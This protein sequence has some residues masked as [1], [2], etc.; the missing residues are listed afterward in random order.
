MKTI[1]FILPYF[2]CGKGNLPEMAQVFFESCKFNQTIEWLFY[3]DCN[4]ER[5]S[6]PDNIIVKEIS[7][8]EIQRRAQNKYDFK[9]CLNY[10]YK[11]C[12]FKPAYGEIFEEELEGIDFWGFCDLDII[13]GDIRKFLTDEILENNDRI[14]THGHCSIFRNSEAVNRGYRTL[15][16][17]GCQN[18]KEV[19]MSSESCAFD[20]WAE[21]LGGGYSKIQKL[22]NIKMFDKLIYA[23]IQINRY[24]FHTTRELTKE[25]LFEKKKKNAI[26][27]LDAGKLMEYYVF[28][29]K[30]RSC[31]YLYIHLQK[32]KMNVEK[33]HFE[34]YLIVPPDKIIEGDGVQINRLSLKKLTRGNV[35]TWNLEGQI[36]RYID[37]FVGLLYRR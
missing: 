7:F 26:Y 11:L 8:A 33:G 32:R 18:W 24:F 10:P 16:R 25:Y 27:L 9:V 30:I 19:F 36:R 4:L 20:E 1:R 13:W 23:D 5:F 34:K 14:M 37:I 6:L 15:D 17:K 35:L 3:T 22:N 28:S 31:E 2:T 12:D 21:H 29:K